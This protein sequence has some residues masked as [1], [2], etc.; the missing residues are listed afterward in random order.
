ME[1]QEL[2]TRPLMHAQDLQLWSSVKLSKEVVKNL[3]F[4]LE[5]GYRRDDNLLN[6]KSLLTDVALGYQFNKHIDAT[7]GYRYQ[8]NLENHS[9]RINADVALT[10][11]LDRF[12][13]SS[14]SRFQRRFETDANHTDFFRERLKLSYNIK[15]NPISPFVSVEGFYHFSYLGNQWEALR[16]DIGAQ[17][18]VRKRTKLEVY[19][20]SDRE[21]SVFAPEQN[22]I[23]GIEFKYK[24]K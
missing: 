18:K 15:K 4:S 7:L 2:D 13:I 19:Y 12:T 8:W 17:W 11:D 21:F 24:L 1:A 16:L 20:R 10:K 22:H 14:R 5:Q 23:I 6:T 3:E 9:S